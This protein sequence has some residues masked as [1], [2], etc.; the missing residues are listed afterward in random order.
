MLFNRHGLQQKNWRMVKKGKHILFGCSLFFV[1]GG[2]SVGGLQVANASET[3]SSEVIAKEGVVNNIT[4][5]KLRDN[6]SILEKEK[7][8]EGSNDKAIEKTTQNQDIEKSGS[9]ASTKNSVKKE[10]N[11]KELKDLVDKI[12]KTDI[13]NNSRRNR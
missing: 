13:R 11:K 8:V 7:S 12:K 9:N 3:N 5:E 6:T 4:G 1:V 10:V 2:M